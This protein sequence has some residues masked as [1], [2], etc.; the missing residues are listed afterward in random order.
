MLHVAA[1]PARSYDRLVRINAPAGSRVSREQRRVP[2][3]PRKTDSR[4]RKRVKDKVFNCLLAP[5]AAGARHRKRRELRDAARG[6]GSVPKSLKMGQGIDMNDAAKPAPPNLE[7]PL[8]TGEEAWQMEYD[9]EAFLKAEP[10]AGRLLL[11]QVN[12][13]A[14]GFDSDEWRSASRL[15]REGKAAV[16]VELWTLLVGEPGQVVR[17]A[18]FE[19]HVAEGWFGGVAPAET[20]RLGAEFD[21]GELENRIDRVLLWRWDDDTPQELGKIGAILSMPSNEAWGY[22]VRNRRE[23][24]QKAGAKVRER[25]P[26][27]PHLVGN[28]KRIDAEAEARYHALRP[29]REWTQLLPSQDPATRVRAEAFV[30]LVNAELLDLHIPEDATAGGTSEPL[31]PTARIRP[32]LVFPGVSEVE[33]TERVGGRNRTVRLLWCEEGALPSVEDVNDAHPRALEAKAFAKGGLV[34]PLAGLDGASPVFHA[35]AS[36]FAATGRFALDRDNLPAFI[37][38]FCDH[39]HGDDGPFRVVESVEDAAL[40][41]FWHKEAA[42]LQPV[43]RPVR[44]WDDWTGEDPEYDRV[45]SKGS[46]T[47][48]AEATIIYAGCVFRNI[49]AVNENGDIGMLEDDPVLEGL[50]TRLGRASLKNAFV[51]STFPEATK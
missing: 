7:E 50:S 9:L 35:F 14:A 32:T 29:R 45:A 22:L 8:L 11:A 16:A 41:G 30:K 46:H 33:L 26:L 39:V 15:R 44:I 2:P 13:R 17:Y 48:V 4:S 34:M 51:L 25:D 10:I 23:K 47:F 5:K 43:I 24:Y 38:L 31:P 3:R 12:E 27:F 6:A 36:L 21:D 37:R 20:E 1:S 28:L 49:F 42:A 19:H 40:K 18:V